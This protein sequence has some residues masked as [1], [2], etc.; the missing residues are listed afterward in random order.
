MSVHIEGRR[1]FQKS[2][3]NTYHT[4]RIYEDSKQ[5]LLSAMEY[6]YGEQYLET[7]LAWLEKEGKIPMR[8]RYAN[9]GREPGWQ[10]LK[11]NGFT[12]SVIDVQRKRD[13]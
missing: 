10:T 8:E 3:G 5:I 6:G 1:W 9:G 2:N 7:A 4:V 11:S 13:L 12:C